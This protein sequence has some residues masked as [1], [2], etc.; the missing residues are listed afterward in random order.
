[1]IWGESSG[2]LYPGDV[3]TG[4]IWGNPPRSFTEQSLEQEEAELGAAAPGTR[5]SYMDPQVLR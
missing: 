2:V 3:R 5:R 4:K 1:M